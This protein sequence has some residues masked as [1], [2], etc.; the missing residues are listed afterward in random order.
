MKA[1]LSA[2]DSAARPARVLVVDDQEFLREVL[3]EFLEVAGYEVRVA[4]DGQAAMT[5]LKETTFDVVVTDLEMPKIDGLSLV[6]EINRTNPG[7]ITIV[8]TGYG[9][10][11]TA[12]EAMKHG[13]SEYIEKP[14][15]VEQVVASVNAAVRNH[16]SGRPRS[17]ADNVRLQV[18]EEA[19]ERV[20]DEVRVVYHPIVDA[21]TARVFGYEA[22]M[23]SR[24]P[25][26]SSPPAV[27][28]AAEQ[29]D[30]I[31]D[32]GRVL[33]ERA[34][35]GFARAPG[36]TLLFFNL[37]PFELQDPAL[38]DPTAPLSNMANR[39]VLEITERAP[40]DGMDDAVDRV[41]ELRQMGYRIAIDDL[42]AGYAGLNSFA[43]LEPEIIK[44]DMSLVREVHERKT[45]QRVIRSMQSLARDLNMRVVAEGVETAQER[46]ALLELGCD[47]LQ[48][49]YFAKP[50]PV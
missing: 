11:E 4:E 31:S 28:G 48:G 7:A 17:S 15:T 16:R 8:M 9:T 1:P 46:D 36:N 3:A 43:E 47:L 2:P 49:F 38:Y 45:K 22:L 26:L 20:L 32:L 25:L 37:H 33:R 35:E 40:L 19:F 41:S 6:K 23:R 13:A 42:G 18:L 29:L 50:G 24:D 10:V 34:V 30:R 12:L 27:L 14:F 21:R 5:E 39:V 44:L